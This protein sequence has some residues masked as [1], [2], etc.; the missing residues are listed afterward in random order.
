MRERQSRVL[1]PERG[2]DEIKDSVDQS[3]DEH[4]GGVDVNLDSGRPGPLSKRV[5]GIINVMALVD[6]NP[7]RP[8]HRR[9]L[10]QA[11]QPRDGR[12]PEN[13]GVKN[14]GGGS[15]HLPRFRPTV[16]VGISALAAGAGGDNRCL[17]DIRKIGG[18]ID[19]CPGRASVEDD[20]A[21]VVVIRAHGTEGNPERRQHSSVRFGGQQVGQDDWL[22]TVDDG[23]LQSTARRSPTSA[24]RGTC[25]ASV[26]SPMLLA[27]S[28]TWM[29]RAVETPTV[30]LRGSG[31][32]R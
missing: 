5:V 25:S 14:D 12:A 4:P 29:S 3:A 32:A 24:F 16:A 18:Q 1:M 13:I 20:A 2:I 27:S 15:V 17:Q 6:Q 28:L 23:Q 10:R 21:A 11:G 22:A 26:S 31:S 7:D 9:E 30:S 8:V 19:Q